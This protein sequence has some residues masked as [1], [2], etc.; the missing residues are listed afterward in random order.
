VIARIVVR[1]A[2][3]AVGSFHPL[4]L[5]VPG[6]APL[7]LRARVGFNGDGT[8]GFMIDAFAV[9]KARF[10]ALLEQLT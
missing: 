7:S 5:C 3:M 8:V 2:P 1:S 9:E 4:A 6:L 10:E